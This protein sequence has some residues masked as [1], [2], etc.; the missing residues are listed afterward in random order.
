MLS[1]LLLRFRV[2]W[3]QLT[4][5][6]IN[7]QV[8][9]AAVT[10]AAVSLIPKGLSFAKE[11]IVASIFGLAGE[12]EAYLV[13]FALIGLPSSLLL[14]ALQSTMIPSMVG[15][16]ADGNQDRR[17]RLLR[18]TVSISIIGF[19]IFL[20]ALPL[21]PHVINAIVG[22]W[23]ESR[24]LQAVSFSY[25][26]VPYYAISTLSG[27]GYG[28]LQA[29]KRF[30]ENALIPSVIPVC[31]M[32]AL[33]IS[34][35]TAKGWILVSGITLGAV[36]EYVWLSTV[37]WRREKLVMIPGKFIYDGL[38][39]MVRQFTFLLP[40]TMIMAFLPMVDQA[41]A[42]RIGDGAVAVMNF[43]NRI[44]ATITSVL[45]TALSVAVLP[46]VSHLVVTGNYEQIRNS[47]HRWSFLLGCG[48]AIATA[49]LIAITPW[50]VQL[51]F[52]RGEFNEE[53][54]NIVSDVQRLYLLQTPGMLIGIIATRVILALEVS[55][56]LTFVALGSIICYPILAWSLS[57]W[58]G[59]P[60][61]GLATAIMYSANA[62]ILVWYAT[63]K[64]AF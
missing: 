1:E 11:A 57:K 34:G 43:G 38:S 49:I 15:A 42:S 8:A 16:G 40:G 14:N 52:E 51:T 64:L 30:I 58:I 56:A 20:T 5:S 3:D 4:Q 2:R 33:Y 22:Q 50:L 27:L 23:P 44:P 19:C 63:K 10:T 17:R 7:R 28:I 55:L 39:P 29:G 21:I 62:V 53:A 54:T 47:L 61:I 31:T 6:T 32:L 46:Y 25:G 12:L 13:A 45:V 36:C 59:I 60:G 26:L 18:G 48:S 37:I 35:N 41:I 9:G 24:K